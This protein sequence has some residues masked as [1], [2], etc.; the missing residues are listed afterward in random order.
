MASLP[1]KPVRQRVV[2]AVE[3][4]LVQNDAEIIYSAL[5]DAGLLVSDAAI[6]YEEDA[7]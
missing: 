2:E 6:L 3:P 4:L 7:L 5:Y 1:D